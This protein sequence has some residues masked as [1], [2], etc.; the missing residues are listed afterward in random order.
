MIFSY[1]M[2]THIFTTIHFSPTHSVNTT[3]KQDV[4]IQLRL[5]INQKKYLNPCIDHRQ[6]RNKFQLST[7]T[8]EQELFMPK[9][10]RSGIE[11]LHMLDRLT[12]FSLHWLRQHL[13]SAPA[14]PP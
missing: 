5:N 12:L 13:I 3:M 7:T 9:L 4:S 2:I 10:N 8:N 11:Q 1:R 14:Q 6:Q